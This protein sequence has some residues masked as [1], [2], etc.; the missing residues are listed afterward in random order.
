[1]LRSFAVVHVDAES[2]GETETTIAFYRS[3]AVSAE[4]PRA[5]VRDVSQIEDRPNRRNH[6]RT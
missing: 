3:G 2:F 4:Y 1:M 5:L 6:P